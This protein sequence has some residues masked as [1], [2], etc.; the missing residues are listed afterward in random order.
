MGAA[1][2]MTLSLIMLIV[3]LFF[4]IVRGTITLCSLIVQGVIWTCIGIVRFARFIR[5][6]AIAA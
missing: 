2:S 1:L 4:L 6:R 5:D 3:R